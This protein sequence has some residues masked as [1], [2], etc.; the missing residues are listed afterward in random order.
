MSFKSQYLE[1]KESFSDNYNLAHN[2][3]KNRNTT[4]SESPQI[5]N[6][7]PTYN[8]F[9][10]AWTCYKKNNKYICPMRGDK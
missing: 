1:F 3:N 8:P 2:N 7:K 6:N 10:M 4:D 9:P 5:E